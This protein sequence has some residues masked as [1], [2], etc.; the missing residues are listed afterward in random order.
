VQL[1]KKG[2]PMNYR[3]DLISLSFLLLFF[4]SSNI[5]CETHTTKPPK[6]VG[7]VPVRNEAPIIAQCLRAL[8]CYTDAIVVLDDASVDATVAVVKSIQ[9]ECNVERIIEKEIWYRDEPGDRNKLLRAGREIG[10]THFIS[11]DADELFTA[12]CRENNF[13][14]NKILSMQPGDYLSFNL[15]SLWKGIGQYRN[16]GNFVIKE[17]AF[18][19]DGYC[20]FESGFIHTLRR[21]GNLIDGKE[22]KIF[23]RETY[24]IL[25]FDR[26][27]WDNVLIKTIWYKCMERIRLPEKS[28]GRINYFYKRWTDETGIQ[29]YP[30]PK[31]WFDGYEFFDASVYN[32]KDV[33]RENQIKQWVRAYGQEYFE[34]LG[35]MLV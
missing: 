28:I 21:P 26:V 15:I 24:G 31:E 18:C 34:G 22:I 12:N 2:K 3:K 14:R 32:Y 1:T 30:S 4:F 11:V 29:L 33:W 19:D 6:I 17:I 23:P 8:A 35:F 20:F 9:K 25:H 7:L 10:G 5:T 13:L 27:N 16:D